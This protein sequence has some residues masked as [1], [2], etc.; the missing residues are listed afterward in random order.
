MKQI[1]VV[2]G[3]NFGDEGKGLMT[4]YFCNK[5]QTKE[6]SCIVVCSNGGA[7]R[8]HSVLT[9]EGVRHVFHHFGAGTFSGACTYLPKPFI[10]NPITF[11]KE[12]EELAALGYFPIV[13]VNPDCRVTTPYDM[14]LNQILEEHRNAEKHG[15]CGMGIYETIHRS[16]ADYGTSAK[17]IL[18]SGSK[19]IS[20]IM[21]EYLPKRISEFGF[22]IPDDWKEI[23]YNPGIMDAYL[24]DCVYMRERIQ[25]ATDEVLKLYSNIVFEN[26]QGLL[27]DCENMEYF[28]HLT[29]SHTG[30]KNPADIINKTFEHEECDIEI[31]YVTR[32]YMTRHGAGRLDSECKKEE[33]NPDM[34]DLTNIPNIHQDSLRYGHL[35]LDTLL[36]RIYNDIIDFSIT[37]KIKTSVAVTHI[38]EYDLPN[39]DVIENIYKLKINPFN[40]NLY[41]S[42]GET[43]DDVLIAF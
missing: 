31:C 30:I 28:P 11:R 37:K 36:K 1:K 34:Q 39:R 6:E 20:N 5:A 40:G 41:L 7:Q 19:D 38:N 32:T 17:S 25:F 8:G 12:Y 21:K 13:Y 29:P 4:D 26:G 23:L 35:V 33:L 43:R 10:I 3:A 18:Q 15:S 2:I 9:S 14:M 42:N 16:E 22:E 27:L 24:D